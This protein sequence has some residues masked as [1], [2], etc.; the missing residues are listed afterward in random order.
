MSP[1]HAK[2]VVLAC[3]V[4]HNFLRDKKCEVYTPPGFGDCLDVN[5]AVVPGR[6]RQDQHEMEGILATRSRN[7][8]SVAADVRLTLVRYLNDDAPLAWQLQHINRT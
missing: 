2:T 5:G 6:F 8:A 7:P 1:D 4:L 3:C